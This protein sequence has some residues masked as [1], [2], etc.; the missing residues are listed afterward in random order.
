MTSTDSHTSKI[1][2]KYGARAESE[3][4][5][6][7]QVSTFLSEF[8]TFSSKRGLISITAELKNSPR[9]R[10]R[11][12]SQEAAQG[13]TEV[14]LLSQIEI[15]GGPRKSK[16]ENFKDQSQ[17]QMITAPHPQV[18]VEVTAATTIGYWLAL[19][20]WITPWRKKSKEW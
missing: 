20:Y 2:K 6:Q 13:I 7:V 11:S 10:T 3:P 18:P 8:L 16:E 5:N 1:S 17:V 12:Q 9:L 15:N 4:E 19:W 14:D